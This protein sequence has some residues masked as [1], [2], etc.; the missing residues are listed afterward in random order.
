LCRQPREGDNETY[1][2]VGPEGLSYRDLITKIAQKMGHEIEIEAIPV[3]L[4]KAGAAFN[5]ILRGGGISPTVIDVITSD[6]KVTENADQRLGIRL[7]PLDTTLDKIIKD[8]T[9]S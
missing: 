9:T 5:S 7:T 1:E 3:W 2:L 6:E 8:Q 4:A